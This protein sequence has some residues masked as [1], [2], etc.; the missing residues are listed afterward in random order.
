MFTSPL[1][2]FGTSRNNLYHH[3]ILFESSFNCHFDMYV[4]PD[5]FEPLTANDGLPIKNIKMIR[6][7]E[8]RGSIILAH[9]PGMQDEYFDLLKNEGF[10]NIY[11]ARRN[12]NSLSVKEKFQYEKKYGWNINF[13]VP[14]REQPIKNL[15]DKLKIYV[16]TSQFDLHKQRD[17][18]TGAVDSFPKFTEYIQAGAALSQIKMCDLRDNTGN[19]ISQKNPTHC[20]LTALWW[21]LKNERLKEY[22][23]FNFYSRIFDFTQDELV[24]ILSNGIDAIVPEPVMVLWKKNLSPNLRSISSLENTIPFIKQLNNAIMNTHAD[25]IADFRSII[26]G[27]NDASPFKYF[28]SQKRYFLRLRRMAFRHTEHI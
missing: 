15:V 20:E 24:S 21:I 2:L 5:E 9:M 19:N 25:Y 13:A 8:R 14:K 6:Q 7:E 28:H 23:G 18:V 27:G 17:N 11:F 1:M 10:E 16:V 22:I 4:I 26:W 12:F 3:K